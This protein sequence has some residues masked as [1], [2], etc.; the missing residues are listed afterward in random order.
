MIDTLTPPFPTQPAA[1]ANAARPSASA[2][3]FADSLRSSIDEVAQTQNTAADAVNALA[4]GQTSDLSG[5]MIAV[6]KGDLAFKTLLAIR[7]KLVEAYDELKA[8]P[9]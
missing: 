4:T 8:M 3:S 7:S 1:P 5:V 2:N 6:E 9:M